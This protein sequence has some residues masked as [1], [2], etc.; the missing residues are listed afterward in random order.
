MNVLEKIVAEKRIWLAE[1]KRTFP[2]DSFRGNVQ[3]SDR[4]FY[5]ALEARKRAGVPA[6]I[7]ECKK[8]SPSQGLIRENFVPAEIAATYARFA[9]AISVLCDEKFFQGRYEN[10]ELVRGN[11]PQP[12]L[13]KDFIIDE[14]QIFLARHFGA[15]AVLLMLSVLNDADYSRLAALAHALGMGILTEADAPEDVARA[16]RLG[17][18]VIGINNRNLRTLKTDLS[19]T[20][21]LAD[22]IRPEAV[23]V[24]ESGLHTHTDALAMAHFADAFLV[25]TALMRERRLDRACRRLIF[26]ENKV[27]GL[28]REV[29]A[30]AARDAGAV[31]GGVIFAEKS[32]RNVSRERAEKIIA[33]AP[34]LDFVGVFK[35][36][37]LEFVAETASRLK[38]FA[39]QLHGNESSEFA[40]A[41]REK[42][43][44]GTQIWKAIPSK[45]LAAFAANDRCAGEN[46]ALAAQ[47]R[48]WLEAPIFDRF[49]L[50][51]GGGGT[52][53]S[54]DWA[55]VP[56]ALKSKSMLAGGISPKNARAAHRVGCVGVEFN[57][58]VESAP[59]E[60]S[61]SLLGEAFDALRKF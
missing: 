55:L 16:N 33:A 2:L 50:D 61:V 13:C 32:P 18:R 4:D 20:R 36:S 6:F 39:V 46:D 52:G 47:A 41:L 7:L 48:A 15:N 25:G 5:G 37:P 17:A 27:C 42:I 56:A 40:V 8:A 38:F 59:G 49:V 51:S 28:T 45:N 30:V 21:E 35:N 11:A 60:K 44:A 29:D 26:G 1:K 23:R 12:V 14:Y 31:F 19:R 57:S 3:P 22:A 58:G 10:L 54:F 53:T 34:E 9:D 43:P 24:A